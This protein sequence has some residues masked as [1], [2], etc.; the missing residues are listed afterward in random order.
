M[1][2]AS[3]FNHDQQADAVHIIA[4]LSGKSPAHQ[5]MKR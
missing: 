1:Q 5:K 3:S 4:S 2:A